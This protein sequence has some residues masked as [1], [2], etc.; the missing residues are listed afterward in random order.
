MKNK[1][2]FMGVFRHLLAGAGVFMV[3]TGRADTQEVAT[4]TANAETLVGSGMVV[5]GIVMSWLA[6]EKK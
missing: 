5:G 4:F 1:A 3:A 2:K 6:P